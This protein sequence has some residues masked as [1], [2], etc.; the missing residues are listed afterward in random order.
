MKKAA[1]ALTGSQIS[2]PQTSEDYPVNRFQ[3]K[4]SHK[5]LTNENP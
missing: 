1:D 4:L 5:T 3:R 2:E